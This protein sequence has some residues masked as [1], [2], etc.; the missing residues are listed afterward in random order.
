[1]CGRAGSIIYKSKFSQ[2]SCRAKD[3]LLSLS[4]YLALLLFLLCFS[5][6]LIVLIL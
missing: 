6:L 1:M 5:S 4:L 3:F 2:H